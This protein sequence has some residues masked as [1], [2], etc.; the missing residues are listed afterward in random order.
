LTASAYEALSRAYHVAGDRAASAEWKAK[1]V[2]QLELVE[3]LDDRE[4]VARDI[5][6]LP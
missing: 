4:I 3:D 2:A 5:A 6:T 1:A